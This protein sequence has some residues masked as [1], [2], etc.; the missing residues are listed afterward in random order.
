M[1]K[2]IFGCLTFVF[3]IQDFTFLQ[4]VPVIVY[5]QNN[6]SD[7]QKVVSELVRYG[8]PFSER[9]VSQNRKSRDEM[10][11]IMKKYKW[12]AKNSTM[13]IIRTERKV[14]ATG[15]RNLQDIIH[16]LSGKTSTNSPSS[17][18]MPA[19]QVS[20]K[21]VPSEPEKMKGMVARH[22]YWRAKLGIAPLVWSEEMA[23]LATDWAEKLADKGCEMQHRPQNKFGE[24]IFW[25]KGYQATPQEVAD[26]WADEQ[27]DFNFNTLT[28]NKDWH[29]CGHYTQ[30]IWETTK[31]VGCGMAKCPGGQEIWVCNYN[32]PGNWTGQ[33]PYKKK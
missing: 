21:S 17:P 4:E 26:A 18:E 19:N 1:K 29:V 28:C 14:Y 8:I 9:N 16:D 24:N 15:T 12:T 6:C 27:K 5:T 32:P 20:T 7:C 13:P 22:N 3:F 11:A 23:E 30:L 33:K 10:N 2:Y 25:C 31:E